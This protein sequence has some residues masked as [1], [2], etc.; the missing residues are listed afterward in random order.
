MTW[1]L[2]S[3]TI[4]A[5][6]I[7]TPR[8]RF[9]T[10]FT[11]VYLAAGVAGAFILE[12]FEFLF[13]ET[14]MLLIIG[15]VVYMDKRVQFSPLVLWGL[16]LWGLLHL[17]GG[18]LPIP[19]SITEPDSTQVLYNMRLAP[20]LPKY[21]Q[22]VHALGFGFGAIAAYEALSKH[23]GFKVP[24]NFSIGATV[25]LIACGLGA[26]NEIIE[27]VAVLVMPETN[28][29]GYVNTGWDLVSNATGALLAILYLKTVRKL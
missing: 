13:Y 2:G 11:L 9:V 24:V 14:A 29:G 20:F 28:V 3:C 19:L 4:R 6:Y 23:L 16:A 10:I 25:F 15:L 26:V 22:F 7:F 12:N 8:L 1:G 27:F 5:M 21:D 17:C 18:L